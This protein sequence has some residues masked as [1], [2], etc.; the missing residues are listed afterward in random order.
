MHIDNEA[1]RPG[2]GRRILS[3]YVLGNQRSWFPNIWVDLP[4]SPSWRL[5][6]GVC[7]KREQ[8]PP[9]DY[10]EQQAKFGRDTEGEL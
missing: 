1:L 3:E 9:L 2:N 5:R 6:E 8:S 4:T 7:A 10:C